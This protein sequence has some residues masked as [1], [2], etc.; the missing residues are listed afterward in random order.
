MAN[1]AEGFKA[2]QCEKQAG[3]WETAAQKIACSKNPSGSACTAAA[4]PQPSSA[5]A[6]NNPQCTF[7]YWPQEPCGHELD[8]FCERVAPFEAACRFGLA[9]GEQ[10][11]MSRANDAY[12]HSR[13]NK[14]SV[15]GAT[16]DLLVTCECCTLVSR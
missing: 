5:S 3:P 2:P 13:S 8:K 1:N 16:Q 15:G 14:Q 11:S 4:F 10:P 12:E 7:A 9:D 6:H